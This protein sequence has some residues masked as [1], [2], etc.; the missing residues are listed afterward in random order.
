MVTHY[1]DVTV[2]ALCRVERVWE[3]DLFPLMICIGHVATPVGHPHTY[4]ELHIVVDRLP[5]TLVL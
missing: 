4:K 2:C 3:G 5:G 1:S